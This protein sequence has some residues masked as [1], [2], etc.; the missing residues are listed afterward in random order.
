MTRPI[1]PVQASFPPPPQRDG[2]NKLSSVSTPD[3]RVPV[4]D[5][6]KVDPKLREAAE[7]MEGVFLDYMMNVMR[8]TIPKNEMDME[9]PATKIYRS[10]L[11]TEVAQKAARSGGIGLADQIIAYMLSAGYTENKG[12]IPPADS[13]DG[14][15]EARIGGTNEGR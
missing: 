3:K 1:A 9:S 14:V 5:R 6:S 10:M 4:I 11:D 7:G 12:S 8:Q 13:Q 15:S 2:V